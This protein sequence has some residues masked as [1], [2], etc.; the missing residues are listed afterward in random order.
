V[1]AES[2][3]TNIDDRHAR[4]GP[5]G[6]GVVKNILP[7]IEGEETKVAKDTKKILSEASDGRII[8]ACITVHSTCTRVHVETVHTEAVHLGTVQH[9]GVDEVKYLLSGYRSEPQEL[10]LSSSPEHPILVVDEEDMPQP[11][12][13]KEYPSMVTLVGWLR[14]NDIFENGLSYVLTIDNLEKGAGGGAILIAEY[15]YVK[16]YL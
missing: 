7:F 5:Y 4:Q 12:K 11:L 16:G 3:I 1:L 14:E 9:H 13:H 10:R 2:N 15:L 6:S 8:E